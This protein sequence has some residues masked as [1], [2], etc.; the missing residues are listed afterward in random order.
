VAR[1]R[2]K[3]FDAG[4]VD[5]AMGRAPRGMAETASA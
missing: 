3:R 5:S 4:G 1:A 2:D